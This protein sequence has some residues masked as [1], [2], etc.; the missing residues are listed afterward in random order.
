[1]KTH[2]HVVSV[3]ESGD[4]SGFDEELIDTDQTADVTRGHIFDGFNIT[5]HHQN[6]TLDGLFANVFL[7][8][9]GVVGA[10]DAGFHASGNLKI[11]HLSAI[12][13]QKHEKDIIHDILY[14]KLVV[15]NE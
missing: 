7:L 14:Q 15:R 11:H 1:M 9:R 6:S 8:S 13:L 12:A 3:L 5:T 4:G 2:L 10:H